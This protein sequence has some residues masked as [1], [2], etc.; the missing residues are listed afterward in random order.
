MT[1]E[2]VSAD[3][4][5]ATDKP[6]HVSD[7]TRRVR[8]DRAGATPH[9]L[10]H[11]RLA[12][13][14]GRIQEPGRTVVRLGGAG[15]ARHLRAHRQRERLQVLLVHPSPALALLGNVATP[16]ARAAG[17]RDP[18]SDD[19]RLPSCGGEP[20]GRPSSWGGS[21][22]CGVG[23]PWNGRRRRFACPAES[24]DESVQLDERV[25]LI[26][27]PAANR[28]SL[29]QACNRGDGA[30]RRLSSA[31]MSIS[32]MVKASSRAVSLLQTFGGCPESSL[33]GETLGQTQP[34][35][36]AAS[37]RFPGHISETGSRAELSTALM[38]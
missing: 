26:G 13:A 16:S 2:N 31:Q 33:Q 4:I 38:L 15:F 10:A 22:R 27:V 37:A 23:S 14:G 32:C 6:Q 5:R 8:R 20:G 3:A 30:Y 7:D 25:T 35:L 18:S 34:R 19:R 28:L 17:V 21:A 1:S 9:P 24:G 11:D 36:I 12:R 29:L